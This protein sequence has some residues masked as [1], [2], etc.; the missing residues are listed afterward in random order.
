M[1]AMYALADVIV[2][3]SGAGAVFEVMAVKKPALFIPL[4]KQTRGDQQQNAEYFSSKGLCRILP[5]GDLDALPIQAQNTS[6]DQTLKEKLE[7]VSLPVGNAFI[8]QTLLDT[9]Q[10]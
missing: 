4:T 7:S 6:T 3:R 9:I 5:Q 8:L 1:G 10:A 2:S